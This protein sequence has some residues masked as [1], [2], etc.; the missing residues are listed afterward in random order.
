MIPDVP[1]TQIQAALDRFDREL[2]D[3]PKW[4]DWE[5]KENFEYALVDHGVRYP[6]KEV[7]RLAT[8]GFDDFIS[9]EARTWLEKRGFQV[10]RLDQG[11][12][13][14]LPM[15][16]M[17]GT[18]AGLNGERQIQIALQTIAENSGMATIGQIYAA[19]ERHLPARTKL[20]KQGQDTLR[21]YIN[22]QAVQ[23]GFVE[24][25]DSARPGWHMTPIGE[26]YLRA[27]QPTAAPSMEE[28]LARVV[29]RLNSETQWPPIAPSL[30]FVVTF[31]REVPIQHYGR[32]Y[33]FGTYS[34]GD[35]R[36]LLEAAQRAQTGGPPVYLIL[37]RPGPTYAFTAWAQVTSIQELAPDGTERQR[38]RRWQLTL[39]QHEFPTSLSLKGNAAGLM[40][41]LPWLAAGLTSA[42]AYRSI[43]LIPASDFETLIA[44]AKDP[45]LLPPASSFSWP[46]ALNGPA[47]ALLY[48]PDEEC[49]M[50][51]P[52]AFCVS[53]HRDGSYAQLIADAQA[54]ESSGRPV[55]VLL[56]HPETK[57]ITG[58]AQVMG[59]R[60]VKRQTSNE[61][62]TVLNLHRHLFPLPLV[63][64]DHPDLTG[65]VAWLGKGVAEAFKRN[66]V[67][68][69]TA[70]D[71]A[72]LI[73]AAPP[74]QWRMDYADR[75]R[76]SRLARRRRP[77]HPGRIAAPRRGTGRSRPKPA[78][79]PHEPH[80]RPPHR[81]ALHRSG[82]RLLEAGGS[83]YRR[84]GAGIG[85]LAH[86]LPA[87]ALEGSPRRRR[88][89]H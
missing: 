4:S 33:A 56:T 38:E 74:A 40:H 27:N 12:L 11:D 36:K 52:D 31:G 83:T 43:R 25:Y 17:T 16:E 29:A 47:Y 9:T 1:R 87:G 72:F 64:P 10:I 21:S 45:T 59:A 44:G 14:A 70:D 18:E 73:D 51:G 86:P 34:S 39:N 57:A 19:V 23:Q 77:A 35:H 60:D 89:R 75:C 76:R 13:P 65:T 55:Y 6:V 80:Q 61:K 5:Q 62:W 8:S 41:S 37:Y 53:H 71:W 20:S 84:G 85:H 67:Q 28:R 54:I 69:L 50:N 88:D 7:V 81:S 63:L 78:A 32:T 48:E 66:S 26:A 22:R 49:R 46:P 68:V 79:H 82:Q 42:F 3:T 24:P 58:W 2:R 30:A 15:R